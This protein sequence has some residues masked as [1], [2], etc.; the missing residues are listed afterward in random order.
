MGTKEAFF[1]RGAEMLGLP[2]NTTKDITRDS[3]RPQENAILQPGGTAGRTTD[4]SRLVWPEA[5][6][7]T[8]CGYCVE[9]CYEPRQAP[10]NLKAKRSTDDSYVPMA[11]TASRWQ[12]GGRD[13]MLLTDAFATASAPCATGV[14]PWPT[15]SPGAS[16]PQGRRSPRRPKSSS[17]P[18][19]PPNRP[20]CG[21]TP[22]SRT[23][24]TGSAVATPTTLSTG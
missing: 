6:G 16:A 15:T 8:L 14:K 13:V 4:A 2:L 10:R 12:P 19:A 18:A 22:V 20:A 5:Q 7:C 9:G 24:T 23:P 1:F 17:W 3:F 11:L 21:S